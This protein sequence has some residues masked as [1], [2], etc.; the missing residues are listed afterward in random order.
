MDFAILG[1][2]YADFFWVEVAM[3]PAIYTYKLRLEFSILNRLMDLVKSKGRPKTVDFRSTEEDTYYAREVTMKPKGIRS[4][5]A[6][7]S[8][9]VHT[10][11]GTTT[12]AN[13]VRTHNPQDSQ[14]GVILA[15]TDVEVKSTDA[16][17]LKDSSDNSLEMLPTVYYRDEIYAGP[18]GRIPLPH[19]GG[20]CSCCT[21]GTGG[22]IFI[23][24]PAQDQSEIDRELDRL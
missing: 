9:A 20:H 21:Y 5:G 24:E 11:D 2:E 23:P 8:V 22:G 1:T 6:T 18:T 16:I 17:C 12:G 7:Y 3:K 15:T 13:P 14:Q 19:P 4:Q 10:N